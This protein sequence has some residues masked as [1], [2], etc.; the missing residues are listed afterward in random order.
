MEARAAQ[1]AADAYDRLQDQAALSFLEPGAEKGISMTQLRDDVLR[2]EFNASR[3]QRLWTR[4]Q[5]KVERNSNIRAGVRTTAT[6]D[7]ARMWEW[8]GPVKRLE[9][10]R[11]ESGR[12][13]LGTGSS[14]PSGNRVAKEVKNPHNA[15][16]IGPATKQLQQHRQPFAPTNH[17]ANTV[18]MVNVPKTRRTYCKG[19]DCKKHTQHKVTQYK[20]GKASLFAQGKRRYDR[21][22]SGYGGQTKPVF[23]KRAKTT[24]KVV[25]RLECTACKTK[26]QLALKRCKHFEL[27]GD[28]KTKGA[29]LVF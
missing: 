9:D 20:A 4:V 7:V 21:K 10:G 18:K 3:R 16:N 19:K 2:T 6:G 23:H 22:Q 25:L 27:G 15:S 5:A 12:F 13:S 28:K 14:P 29:A 17:R 8:I 26:A 11:R 1:L 24:K